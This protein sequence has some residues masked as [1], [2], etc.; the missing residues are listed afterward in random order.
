MLRATFTPIDV[1]HLDLM[2]TEVLPLQAPTYPAARSREHWLWGTAAIAFLAFAVISPPF[3]LGQRSETR[4]FPILSHQIIPANSVSRVGQTL[5]W[6][7]SRDKER[8]AEILDLDV[9]LDTADGDIYSPEVFRAD[10]GVPWHKGGALPPGQYSTRFCTTVPAR[11]SQDMS[12][13]LRQAVTYNGF[14]GLWAIRV[15]LPTII[16]N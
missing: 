10:T 8:V 7:W 12:V 9:D 15:S 13:R 16:A 14:L 3:S 1:D 6:T 4:F 11:V 5:C 2:P